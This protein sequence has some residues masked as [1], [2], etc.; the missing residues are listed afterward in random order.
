MVKTDL[1][2]NEI[3]KAKKPLVYINGIYSDNFSINEKLKK[4]IFEKEISVIFENSIQRQSFNQSDILWENSNNVNF[5]TYLLKD[6]IDNL[7]FSFCQNLTKDLLNEVRLSNPSLDL[8]YQ[9]VKETISLQLADR[10]S[11]LLRSTYMVLESC[12]KNKNDKVIIFTQNIQF[13]LV[14]K[15]MLNA[16]Y[17][18][19]VILN[20][21]NISERTIFEYGNIYKN[22]NIANLLRLPIKNIEIENVLELIKDT[23]RTDDKFILNIT[24]TTDHLYVQAINSVSEYLKEYRIVLIDSIIK[25]N[26]KND[27]EN[28]KIMSFSFDN[29]TFFLGEKETSLLKDD[30]L[31]GLKKDKFYNYEF[32][33]LKLGEYFG[34]FSINQVLSYT[35]SSIFYYKVFYELFKEVIP[36]I[37]LLSPSRTMEGQAL[38]SVARKY[39]IKSFDLQCST[40]AKTKRFWN[41]KTD[42]I[43]CMDSFTQNLYNDLYGIGYEKLILAGSPRMDEKIRKYRNLTKKNN[44]QNTKRIFVALQTLGED[45]NIAFLDTCFEAIKDLDNIEITL[46]FHPKDKNTNKENILKKY[47]LF[48]ATTKDT[49]QELWEHDICIT[50]YSFTGVEAFALGCKVIALN[51]VDR[52]SWPYRL[53]DLGIA[54]EAY[55]SEELKELIIDDKEYDLD[56]SAIVLRDGLSLERISKAIRGA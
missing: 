16:N 37:I 25:K 32:N 5:F 29:K 45:I 36:S 56:E 28:N 14:L 13:S 2:I 44:I 17:I 10:Y 19:C 27:L 54:E 12:L 8:I 21:S 41:P 1:L 33:N 49:L 23:I 4:Y 9:E 48:K 38:I 34:L 40:L 42:F 51:I 22:K 50:Y 6:D 53:K 7:T 47:S 30:F 55:N 11:S 46:G 24:K 26:V 15:K 31:K 18:D 3:S 39:G 52:I 43:F 35:I 20:P